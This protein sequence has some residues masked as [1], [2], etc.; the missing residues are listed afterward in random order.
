MR[1]EK[2]KKDIVIIGVFVKKLNGVKVG[3]YFGSDIKM[4]YRK[5]RCKKNRSKRKSIIAKSNKY[6]AIEIGFHK[7]A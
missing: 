1:V 4:D 5:V 2:R 3:L 6:V 7:Y